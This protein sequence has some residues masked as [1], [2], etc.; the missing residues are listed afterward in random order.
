MN[1]KNNFIKGKTGEDIAKAYLEKKG[2]KIIETNWHY[3]KNAEIDIIAKKGSSL[4]FFEVKTRSSLSFG[5]PFEAIN[6]LKLEKIQK[7][8]TAYLLESSVKYKDYRIDGIAITGFD[9]PVIEH[10]ENIGQY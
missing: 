3:S 10:L 7:A 5:H 6:R 1:L 2:Y 9:N 4:I 8:A